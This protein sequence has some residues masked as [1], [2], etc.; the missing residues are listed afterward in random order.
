MFVVVVVVLVVP[1][2]SLQRRRKRRTKRRRKAQVQTPILVPPSPAVLLAA[3]QCR[4]TR[5]V[6]LWPRRSF[7]SKDGTLVLLCPL[8]RGVPKAMGDPSSL[9]EEPDPACFCPKNEKC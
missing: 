8:Q 1:A 3:S 7:A 2:T 5:L 6:L 4:G 9:T